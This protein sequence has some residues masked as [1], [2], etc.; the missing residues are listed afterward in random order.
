MDGL[1]APPRLS[2]RG[3]RPLNGLRLPDLRL[4]DLPAEDQKL[5]PR[6]RPGMLEGMGRV[7]GPGQAQGSQQVLLG[8]PEPGEGDGALGPSMPPWF[9]LLC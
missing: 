4:D 6:P 5:C 2:T 1:R 7:R 3:L 9:A 8:G